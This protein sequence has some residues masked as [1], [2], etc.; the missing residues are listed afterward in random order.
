[1]KSGKTAKDVVAAV[2]GYGYFPQTIKVLLQKGVTVVSRESFDIQDTITL[3][4]RFLENHEIL[5]AIEEGRLILSPFDRESHSMTYDIVI[6]EH[7]TPDCRQMPHLNLPI[8]KTSE[9]N[10][11]KQAAVSPSIQKYLSLGQFFL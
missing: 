1:M 10:I 6:W 8:S 4:E 11:L 2:V 7:P 5:G 3:H 9:G